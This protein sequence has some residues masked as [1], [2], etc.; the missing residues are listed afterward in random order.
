MNIDE[1]FNY[2]AIWILL[3]VLLHLKHGDDYQKLEVI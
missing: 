1:I 2:P 3:L